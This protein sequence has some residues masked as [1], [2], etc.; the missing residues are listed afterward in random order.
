MRWQRTSICGK[1]SERVVLIRRRRCLSRKISRPR[2]QS[3]WSVCWLKLQFQSICSIFGGVAKAN[4]TRRFSGSILFRRDK[5]M[6]PQKE[7]A[8]LALAVQ[9]RWESADVIAGQIAKELGRTSLHNE[10]RKI[11]IIQSEDQ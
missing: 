3:R 6:L 7:I 5:R 1:K 11:K 2:Q 9:E 4:M 10:F 8:A